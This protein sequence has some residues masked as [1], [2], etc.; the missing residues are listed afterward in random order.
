MHLS[1]IVDN[2]GVMVTYTDQLRPVVLGTMMLGSFFLDLIKLPPSNPDTS[3]T[4]EC[5]AGCTQKLF[6]VEGITVITN[7]FHAHLRGRSMTTDIIRDGKQLEK[8]GEMKHYSFYYQS[9][10]FLPPGG[11][12]IM[13]GDRLIT[14]C[15][16][17]T[18]GDTEQVFG[19]FFLL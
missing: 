6:P 2:S 9:P 1:D 3:L 19:N 12:K 15:H 16:Y 8:L 11:R 18:S 17:D 7:I 5:T 4:S 10:S 14:T 13:P